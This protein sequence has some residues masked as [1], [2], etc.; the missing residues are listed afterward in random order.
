MILIISIRTV[1]EFKRENFP[2]GGTPR[3]LI[4]RG[5]RPGPSNHKLPS[6]GVW[7]HVAIIRL[8]GLIF[9]QYTRVK[10][11]SNLTLLKKEEHK[12]SKIFTPLFC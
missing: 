10:T 11:S 8:R 6:V 2:P 7:A 9:E 3:D 1:L 4:K 5:E 12:H